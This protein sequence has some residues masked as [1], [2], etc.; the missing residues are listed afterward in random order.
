MKKALLFCLSL[1]LL[2][3]P[4][5]FSENLK[6]TN[7]IIQMGNLNS[8]AGESDGS[9]YSLNIT[10]GQT[11]AGL[12]SGTN[13][14]VRSG[15]QYIS[16]IIPFSFSISQLIIDFGALSP[17]NPVS[18]TNILTIDNQSAGG[19][20]VKA[21]QNHH[22]LDPA[23]GAV[24][25]DTTCDGGTCN[26]TTSAA[27]ANT[28]T[29]GFGYRCDPVTTNYCASGFASSG[30]YKQFADKES[31]ETEQ[32]VMLGQAGRDQQA[33]ITY[34]VNISSSQPAGLYTNVITYIATPTY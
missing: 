29:Y 5:A 26:E 19:Y 13:Y 22:L 4:V 15:F 3:P 2:I 18:R 32:T 12:Y 30:Y 1:L 9:G 16:S 23:T 24:I 21:Y 11:G 10:G 27:W 33:E 20:S 8:F 7:Y 28:L 25:P 31:N 17:T 34:K 14:T 6:N